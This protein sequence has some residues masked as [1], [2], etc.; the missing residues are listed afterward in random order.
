MYTLK[1]LDKKHNQRRSIMMTRGKAAAKNLLAKIM[2]D[3]T[4]PA[5][6]TTELLEFL[7]TY[8]N[9]EKNA[10][11]LVGKKQLLLSQVCRLSR[12]SS[13]KN[14]FFLPYF[15]KIGKIKGTKLVLRKIFKDTPDGV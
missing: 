15:D 6:S 11:Q 1:E 8:S 12:Y 4:N 2:G 7:I 14:L 10:I 3:D 5:Q 13:F 9:V